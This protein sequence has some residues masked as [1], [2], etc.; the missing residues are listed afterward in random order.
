M[1][2]YETSRFRTKANLQQQKQGWDLSGWYII[3]QWLTAKF[4]LLSLKHPVLASV[5]DRIPRIIAEHWV[6]WLLLCSC[7]WET[8]ETDISI[9]EV[10]DEQ[11]WWNRKYANGHCKPYD[12][13]FWKTGKMPVL[14]FI[15]IICDRL[16]VS[17]YIV[18]WLHT[19]H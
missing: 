3:L 1:E 16:P 5:S 12:W 17:S 4:L 6:W 18:A 14:P 7:I 10:K 8:S 19:R 11:L 2:G 15:N 13:H 9:N